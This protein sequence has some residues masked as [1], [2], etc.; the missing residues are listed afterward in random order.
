VFGIANEEELALIKPVARALIAGDALR[1]DEF[2][3]LS[4]GPGARPIL[5]GE[6]KVELVVQPKRQRRARGG[7][8][9]GEANPIGD[10]LFEAL[11]AC[12]TALAKEAGVP[13][14]VVFHDSTLREMAALKPESLAALGRVSGVGAAKLDR[15]G[16]A[17]VEVIRTFA[18]AA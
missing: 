4:F 11:R 12:R 15:Y 9:G 1:T 6:E 18:P 8:G 13:P 3:G 7:R 10:P 17:F 2:G 14:Y 16:G 5:K